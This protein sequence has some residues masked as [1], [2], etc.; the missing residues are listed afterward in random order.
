M[1]F[2][3]TGHS[4]SRR[5]IEQPLAGGHST[6]T[7]IDIPVGSDD[8]GDDDA[9][10]CSGRMPVKVSLVQ[11]CSSR[12]VDAN[13]ERCAQLAD[14]AADADWILFPENAPFLG[15]DAEKHSVAEPLDGPIVDHF[16]RIARETDSWVTLGSFPEAAPDDDRSY[17]TQVLFDPDGQTAAVYRKIHLFDVDVEGGRSYRESDSVAGGDEIV[18]ARLDAG[19]SA[20]TAGLTICYDLRFP[21][22][23]RQLASRGAHVLTVPS[24]FT[25]QTGRDHWHPLLQARAI[26]NQAY[27]LAPN[28]W[29]HHFGRR[30]S[31]GHS[32]I[33]DPWGRR[34]ACAPDY[35]CVVSAELDFEYLDDVRQRM[36][37]LSHRRL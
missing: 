15:K 13:L 9:H 34:V 5:P 12:D 37:S 11:L 18:I 20:R 27:V 24:A 33:Y 4:L 14:K 16:R 28:Q 19:D 6:D 3:T 2:E 25:L 30:S 8:F 35:E 17:N 31:Y 36:P 32:A 21:E 26:E 29:G 10:P 23:Y 22:L 7:H 1:R